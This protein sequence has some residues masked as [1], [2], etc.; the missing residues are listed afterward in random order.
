MNI[1]EYYE[2]SKNS[3]YVARMFWITGDDVML[4]KIVHYNTNLLESS[5]PHEKL[6]TRVASLAI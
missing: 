2:C 4:L 5:S 3:N 6:E 1:L